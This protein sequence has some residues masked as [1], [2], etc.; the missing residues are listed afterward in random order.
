[1]SKGVYLI[2]CKYSGVDML[3]IGFSNNVEKRLKQ[4]KTSNIL[5]EP[6][7]FIETDDYKTLEKDIHYKC[8]KYRYNLEF[9]YYKEVIIDLFKNHPNFK[10]NE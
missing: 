5:L 10:D 7:G 4:H 3:K 9:F 2:K 6:I 8:R 1:M